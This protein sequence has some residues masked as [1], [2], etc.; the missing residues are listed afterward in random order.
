MCSCR[1]CVCVCVSLSVYH[2]KCVV[3]VCYYLFV[4]TRREFKVTIMSLFVLLVSIVDKP[5]AADL[6]LYLRSYISDKIHIV[7]L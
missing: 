6:S 1:M 5:S 4:H 2:F 3:Y 7:L